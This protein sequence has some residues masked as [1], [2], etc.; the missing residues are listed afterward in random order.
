MK[1]KFKDN[2]KRYLKI[3]LIIVGC[4]ISIILLDTIQAKIF[5]HSP[6]ISLREELENNDSY[7]DRGVLI[8]TYYCIKEKDIV[9]VSYHFKGDKFI[10]ST[11]NVDEINERTQN[12][13]KLLKEKMIEIEILDDD[14]LESLAFNRIWQYGYYVDSPEKKHIVFEFDYSCKDGTDKCL[15][16][17]FKNYGEK[18]DKHASITAYT[19]EIEIYELEKISIN[20]NDDYKQDYIEIK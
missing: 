12:L 20:I 17:L 2:C 4:L 18:Y 6:I 5:K 3:T 11:N 16:E 1:N 8:D 14:N 10:C 15:P 7:V 9:T 19:D 13:I